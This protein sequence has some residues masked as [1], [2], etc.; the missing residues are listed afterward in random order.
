MPKSKK[1]DDKKK[2]VTKK[3]LTKKPKPIPVQTK[4]NKKANS[5]ETKENKKANSP[6]TK[7]NKKPIPAQTKEN[8]KANSPETKE[9]KKPIPAQTKENKKPIPAQTKENKKVNLQEISKKANS[10]VQRKR[11]NSMD[12]FEKYG[13]DVYKEDEKRQESLGNLVIAFGPSELIKKL[14]SESMK[15]PNMSNK[16][17]NDKK[18]VRDNFKSDKRL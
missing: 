7:E 1:I 4:E 3:S 8:K 11:S 18:W 13:Y 12:L 15:T 5:P 2:S 9:N 14:D 10:P 17:N 6:E 16:F